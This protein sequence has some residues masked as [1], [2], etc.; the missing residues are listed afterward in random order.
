MGTYQK[1]GLLKG[2]DFLVLKPVRQQSQ[3]RFNRT[4]YA[5]TEQPVN[6]A[7]QAEAV[8]YY[9][10]ASDLYQQQLYRELTTE[11]FRGVP[12]VPGQP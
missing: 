10:T 11:D 4:S 6:A 2:D 3:Y 9:Q 1:L 8:S 5:L 7:F 12:A